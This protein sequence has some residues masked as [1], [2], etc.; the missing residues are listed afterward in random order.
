MKV[1]GGLDHCAIQAR[2]G[3]PWERWRSAGMGVSPGRWTLKANR[4]FSLVEVLI[5]LVILAMGVSALG[6]MLLT[7][8]RLQQNNLRLEMASALLS[9]TIDELKTLSNLELHDSR[10]VLDVSAFGGLPAKYK[11]AGID[12]ARPPGYDYLR[13]RGVTL[14]GADG[15]QYPFT[16]KA[17]VDEKYLQQDILNRVQVTVFWPVGRSARPVDSLQAVFFIERK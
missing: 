4:G 14:T 13:W 17:A 16:V 12:V 5:A 8:M 1:P 9:Q 6:G 3:R 11:F 10:H 15:G 7:A 2:P